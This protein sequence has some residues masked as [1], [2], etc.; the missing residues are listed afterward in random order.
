MALLWASLF[1]QISHFEWHVSYIHMH[2]HTHMY[3][4][5]PL[6][7][8]YVCLN[9]VWSFFNPVQYKHIYNT[10][11]KDN[12]VVSVTMGKRIRGFVVACGVGVVVAWS[13][14][15]NLISCNSRNEDG[16]VGTN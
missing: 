16:D 9:L 12:L 1:Q 13:N 8:V 10:E 7:L 14:T 11:M 5:Q 15:F 6:S 3:D 4:C 2:T